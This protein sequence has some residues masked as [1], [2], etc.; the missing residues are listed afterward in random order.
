MFVSHCLIKVKGLCVNINVKNIRYYFCEVLNPKQC[1]YDWYTS[2]L[3][4][5]EK[6][7][8]NDT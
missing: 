5:V 7:L 4:L 8:Y 2:S 3:R 6:N 1:I